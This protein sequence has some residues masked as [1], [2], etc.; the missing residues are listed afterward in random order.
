LD[1]YCRGMDRET[2][3]IILISTAL[4]VLIVNQVILFLAIRS[5]AKRLEALMA[6]WH[7]V[8]RQ[9]ADVQ[10]SLRLPAAGIVPL[11][12]F[13]LFLIRKIIRKNKEA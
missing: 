5:M 6:T 10:K 7:T 13:A 8:L 4:I 3:L 9:A 2:I 11:S 12:S 1:S